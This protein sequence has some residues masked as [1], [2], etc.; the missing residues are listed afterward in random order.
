MIEVPVVAEGALSIPTMANLRKVTDFVA[1]QDE[2]WRED[3]PSEALSAYI[4]AMTSTGQL[5]VGGRCSPDFAGA[6]TGLF[7]M[8]NLQ[9][10]RAVK[11]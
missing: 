7:G 9:S 1:L 3:N 10:Q 5:P 6:L 2:I 4:T 11:R 8:K